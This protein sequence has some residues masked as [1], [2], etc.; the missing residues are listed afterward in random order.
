MGGVNG[1]IEDVLVSKEFCLRLQSN[2]KKQL[3][4]FELG[5]FFAEKLRRKVRQEPERRIGRQ[6]LLVV[7]DG[8]DCNDAMAM[9]LLFLS[10]SSA[11][12]SHNSKQQFFFSLFYLRCT[13]DR[14]RCNCTKFGESAREKD[15][16]SS[17]AAAAVGPLQLLHPYCRRKRRG[18]SRWQSSQPVS[19]S[20]SATT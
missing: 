8:F 17:S 18:E 7:D 12:A 9:A 1:N 5:I 3:W 4:L 15:T 20:T 6:L 13:F 14:F 19:T 16:T 10:S 2:R 11:A